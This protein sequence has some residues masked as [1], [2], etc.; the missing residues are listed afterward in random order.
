MHLDYSIPHLFIVA[1]LNTLQQLDSDPLLFALHESSHDFGD[2][3]GV[4]TLCLNALDIFLIFFTCLL[5]ARPLRNGCLP[6]IAIFDAKSF[7]G[8]CRKF[9]SS[10]G[11]CL[12]TDEASAVGFATVAWLRDG[13]ISVDIVV[14]YELLTSFDF[15]LGKNSHS[16]LVSHHPLVDIAVWATRVIAEA[17]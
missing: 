9:G 10:F 8:S 13:A 5:F 1:S 12:A 17:V 14:E 11:L 15:P 6:T 2:A 7:D 3:V 4:K 16:K